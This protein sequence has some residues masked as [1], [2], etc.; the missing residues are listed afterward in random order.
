LFGTGTGDKIL[1]S[2]EGDFIQQDGEYVK[3]FKNDESGSNASSQVG[4]IRLA[5]GQIVKEIPRRGGSI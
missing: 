5:A 1:Q 4:A 2:I 3:V